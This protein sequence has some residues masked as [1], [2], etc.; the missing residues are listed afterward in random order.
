MQASSTSLTE[1]IR[2][3]AHEFTKAINGVEEPSKL[4]ILL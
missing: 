1:E 4:K 3:I 2:F